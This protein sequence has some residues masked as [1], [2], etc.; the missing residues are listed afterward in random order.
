MSFTTSV[1]Q[2]FP[3]LL[4]KDYFE[5]RLRD[6]GNS[7]QGLLEF[8]WMEGA[9]EDHQTQAQIWLFYYCDII[10]LAYRYKF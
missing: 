3:V 4:C 9:L 7:S 6:L 5:E 10:N 2:A 1:H 8:L